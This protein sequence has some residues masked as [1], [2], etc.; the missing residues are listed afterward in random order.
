M[1]DNDAMD[2]WDL[3]PVPT[4]I[5]SPTCRIERVS[6]GLLDAWGRRSR[7]EFVGKDVF[8][9]LYAGS[10]LKRF[11][12]IPLIRFIDVATNTRKPQLCYAAYSAEDG[13]HWSARV[14][15]IFRGNKLLSLVLEWELVPFKPG[16]LS[17]S[18]AIE[19]T[20]NM[21]SVDETL[22]LLIKNV[23]DYAI[24][25]LDT[26]GYVATWN[27]GAEL[28]KGFKKTDIVGRHFSTFYGD[29]DL[30]NGKP[31][32]ELE[33]CLREGRVE[34][35][36]W[37]YRKDGTRFWANVVITAVYKEGVHVGFGKVTR[38]LTERR[39]AELRLVE[40]YEESAKLK[41]EFLANMSHEIRTPMHGLLSAC[42]LLLDTPLTQNQRE[43]ADLIA[44]AGQMLLQVIN[45]IL[46]Y[47][48]LVSGNVTMT[49]VPVDISNIVSSV[50]RNAQVRLRPE[51]KLQLN[52]SP[53]LP[54]TIQGDPLRYRQVVQ[55]IVDN[56]IKFTEEGSVSVQTSI[57]EEDE[58]TCTILT[59]VTDTGIGLQVTDATAQNLYKPFIQLE[60]SYNKRFQGTGLG[61]SIA[62]SIVELMDGQLGYRPNP[63]RRG[64][65]FWFTAKLKKIPE[66]K[67][68]NRDS[69]ELQLRVASEDAQSLIQRLEEIAP[70]MKLLF[71]EDNLINQQVLRRMLHSFGF[72]QVDVAS[73]GTDAISMLDNAPDKYDLILMDV[74]M[75]I[76]DGLEATAK[77]RESGVKTPI[78]ALTAYA[79]AGDMEKVLEKGMDDYIAKPMKKDLLVQKLLKWLD[80]SD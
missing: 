38:D 32:S 79:L 46:D 37:R 43:L 33:I 47:S 69:I 57:L 56:A 8:D 6:D 20:Q 61:L 26:K 59:N 19:V 9:A 28:L 14:I 78:I 70:Q 44:D 65:V 23:K 67:L 72:S 63:T 5:L 75:P 74:N 68:E 48:K 1:D 42:T 3:S 31:E 21:L 52:L 30:R 80:P 2:L 27:N 39:D 10:S 53:D 16:A 50:V 51:V 4:F 60:Q 77:L 62:K 22:G 12:R 34:D 54:K 18:L 64:S 35:E 25:L 71:A 66:E 17:G 76:M 11:D 7:E 58:E 15:P 13:S 40:A 29:E 36:G 55:N 73:N 41:N 49:S 45:S 24:F